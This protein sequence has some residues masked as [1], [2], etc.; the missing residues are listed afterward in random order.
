MWNG[1]KT[2]RRGNRARR[3]FRKHWV[4]RRD[5]RNFLNPRDKPYIPPEVR[6]GGINKHTVRHFHDIGDGRRQIVLPAELDFEDNYETTAS[7]FHLMRLAARRAF[8]LKLITF[9]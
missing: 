1:R 8:R 6:L 7:H 9:D 4:L 3:L 2:T 5:L